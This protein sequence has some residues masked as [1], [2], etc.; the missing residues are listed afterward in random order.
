MFPPLWFSARPHPSPFF[1]DH[2]GR[3]PTRFSVMITSYGFLPG[4]FCICLSLSN[5][6]SVEVCSRCGDESCR[7]HRGILSG[8]SF[9]SLSFRASFFFLL[10]AGTRLRLALV[11][12]DRFRLLISSIGLLCP[13]LFFD[14]QAFSRRGSRSRIRLPS[15][16]CNTPT[17]AG[18]VSLLFLTCAFFFLL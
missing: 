14:S 6:A 9:P 12:G 16:D 8:G 2:P 1:P 5:H 4:C 7:L 11:T 3:L 15:G 13:H 10:N 18:A 17:A